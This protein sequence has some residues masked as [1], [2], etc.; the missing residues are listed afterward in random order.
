MADKTRTVLVPGAGLTAELA[1]R[2]RQRGVSAV[3]DYLCTFCGRR[4]HEVGLVVI[5][6]SADSLE[7]TVRV[8]AECLIQAGVREIL[9]E[10]PGA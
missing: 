1:I 5:T 8:C 4:R 9:E 7:V 10:A 3:G 2:P 6:L